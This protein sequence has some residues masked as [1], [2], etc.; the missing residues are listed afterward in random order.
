MLTQNA[1]WHVREGTLPHAFGERPVLMLMFAANCP[2]SLTTLKPNNGSTPALPTP[3][4]PQLTSSEFP[5]AQPRLH[6]AVPINT[7]RVHPFHPIF[8]YTP[9]L[10]NLPVFI[11]LRMFS[12]LMVQLPNEGLQLTRVDLSSV[13]HIGSRSTNT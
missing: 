1:H 6:C 5:T 2:Q 11:L 4:T 10:R 8:Y 12:F 9:M 13:D 7:R 3:Q